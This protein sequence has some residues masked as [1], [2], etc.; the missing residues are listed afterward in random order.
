LNFGHTLGHALEA[1]GG[2][3]RLT[4]GE[5][6]SL[7][8][9][10]MLDAG[11]AL[12]VTDPAAAKRVVDLLHRLELPTDLSKE[13]VG[14]ALQLIRLDKK[15]RGEMLRVV[16]LRAIGEAA[17]ADLPLTEVEKLLRGGQTAD[18]G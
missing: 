8:M 7:G 11:V 12:G 3:T 5:A 13:P 10:A 9:V 14:A 18:V 16:L 4:H 1:Q 15:R 2:Y 17:T 6:V